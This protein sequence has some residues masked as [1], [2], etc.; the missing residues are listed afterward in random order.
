LAQPILPNSKTTFTLDFDGQVP[1]QIRRSGRNNAEG[2][3]LS[4]S[5]WYPKLANL[6]LKVGM[7]ILTS[8]ENFTVFGKF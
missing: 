3:E 2:V 5:Q 1:I 4:M 7:Q 6:I 8:P